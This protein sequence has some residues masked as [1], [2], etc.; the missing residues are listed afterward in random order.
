[1]PDPPEV[2]NPIQSSVD[3]H[4]MELS[5]IRQSLVENRGN[6]LAVVTFPKNGSPKPRACDVQAWDKDLHIRMSYDKLMCLGSSKIASMF[7]PKAQERFRRRLNLGML[8]TGVDYVLDFTPP[9]EGP[10][11][12]DLTAML[13]LPRICKLWFLAGHYIPNEI[14]AAGGGV[15]QRPMADKAVGCVLSLGHDDVCSA[16]NCEYL[17]VIL[18][19]MRKHHC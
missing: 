18:V 4:L 19:V 12:A 7:R 6:V 15:P 8:P 3:L 17:S 1:M 5:A 14:L 9:A 10:E 2:P 16:D 13:W 11:L